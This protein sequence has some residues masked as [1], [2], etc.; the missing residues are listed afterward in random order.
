MPWQEKGW[1]GGAS[2][3]MRADEEFA[4]AVAARNRRGNDAADAPAARRDEGRDI[5]AHGNMNERVSHDALLDMSPAGF[6]LRLDQ[7][8]QVRRRL[9]LRSAGRS[10]ASYRRR[11]KAGRG[12]KNS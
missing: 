4:I 1:S 3:A 6:E 5:V 2:G 12:T 11:S 10:R 7:R 9:Q 8:Q